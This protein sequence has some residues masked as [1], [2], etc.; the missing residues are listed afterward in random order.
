MPNTVTEINIPIITAGE[1]SGTVDRHIPDGK[2]GVGGINIMIDNEATGK[3]TKL[4]SF[5][6]GEFYYMGLVPGVYRAV[7]ESEQLNRYG[8]ASD[9]PSISFQ[10][11]TI[12]GGDNVSNLNFLIIPKPESEDK[13]TN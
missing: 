12:A 3:E 6:N 13:S 4:T 7:I 9:P 1:I 5:N 8:Y 10:I 11:K 2:V